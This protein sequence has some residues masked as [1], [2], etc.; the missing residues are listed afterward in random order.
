MLVVEDRAD[1]VPLDLEGVALLVARELGELGHHRH[2]PLGHGLRP[3]VRGRVHAV[4][5]PVL[6]VVAR[7]EERVPAVHA[8]AVERDD[9][10]VVPPLVALVG[11][12][13]PDLHGPGAVLTLRDVALEVDVLD[14]VILGVDRLPVVLRVLRDA[15]RDR[16]GGEHA[17]ALQPQVPVQAPRVVL[18]DHEARRRRAVGLASGRLRSRLEVALPPVVAE[19]LGHSANGSH[20][21]P[22]AAAA[23]R[24]R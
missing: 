23:R 9:R 18:L 19:L 5:H 2:D 11:P 10:L 7:A 16:P 21:E 22:P 6:G 1:A 3:R 4:D 14:R 13:V 15:V 24:T 12:R 17:V 20:R 8:P